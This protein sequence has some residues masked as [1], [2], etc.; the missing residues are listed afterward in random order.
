MLNKFIIYRDNYGVV[1]YHNKFNN[2]YYYLIYMMFKIYLHYMKLSIIN[3]NFK[4]ILV[5]I[6]MNVNKLNL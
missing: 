1:L 3:N 5:M 2:N 4:Y 6:L